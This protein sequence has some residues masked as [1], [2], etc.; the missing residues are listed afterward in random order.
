LRVVVLLLLKYKTTTSYFIL[1]Y[2]QSDILDVV[3]YSDADFIS[4]S[5]DRKSTSAYTFMMA[6]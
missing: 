6:K 1:T 2:R 4:C 5:N 3:G